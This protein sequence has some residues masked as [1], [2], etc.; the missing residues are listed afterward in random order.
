MSH[1]LYWNHQ[2]LEANRRDFDKLPGSN[3]PKSEQDGPT[4]SSRALAI[5]HLAMYD[6][7]VVASGLGPGFP[8]Y[9]SVV[10]APSGTLDPA[11]AVAAAAFTCLLSLF[12][13]QQEHFHAALSGANLGNGFSS[14][15][16]FGVAVAQD[17][18]ED[19]SKDPG[20]SDA[21]Y[22]PPA[23]REAHR[24]DPVKPDQGFHAPF[25][26]KR[27][28]CFAAANRHS[29]QDPMTFPAGMHKKAVQQV[30]EKGIDPN[31]MGTLPPGSS[32]RNPEQSLM[33]L[34]W[35]YDGA[36]GLG[37]PPRLYNLIVRKIVEQRALPV[38]QQ[39]HLFAL[40]N[41]AMGDAGILAWEQ[42]Y[43]HNWWRPVLGV[44]EFDPSM[45][46]HA[47]APGATLDPDSDP[48]WLPL[49]APAT[50]SYVA[51]AD[52]RAE[53]SEPNFTPPFPAY[54][55]GHATFGAAAFQMVRLFLLKDV[56]KELKDDTLFEEDF[57]SEELD[58]KSRDNQGVVRPMH[59][60]RFDRGL[61]QMIEENGWSRIW[62]G[63]HWFYDAFA[64]T[65][66]GLENP[67]LRRHLDG[68]F[69]KNIGGVP[70]GINIAEDIYY[71]RLGPNSGGVSGTSAA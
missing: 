69:V 51:A 18:L 48:Q 14:S 70:L 54:P 64:L 16:E 5:V 66:D 32:A 25:Y 56:A 15:Y 63:V 55:S 41:A 58:G 45:G 9:R 59:K 65:E 50:N 19:R 13:R 17:L 46:P 61:M 26:G 35:A 30:R 43:E 21:G 49:G 11:T 7:H 52:E 31:L 44:R 6:A 2:A 27:S 62:L 34:Y 37:T 22:V 24:E 71:G 12:P 29:I 38:D 23:F 10:S 36:R 20:A 4:L 57:V 53:Y 1:I 40:V 33:G 42:K 68:S 39:A 47:T 60:R 67:D 8:R 28:R 3:K